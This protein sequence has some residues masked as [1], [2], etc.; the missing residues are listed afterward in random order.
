MLY[1]DLSPWQ[2][3]KLNLVIKFAGVLGVSIQ[4]QP[5]YFTDNL[6]DDE[7]AFDVWPDCFL[8]N[9]DFD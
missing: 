8:G 9:G 4:V 2:T 6:E 5:Q 3:F 7:L 1:K